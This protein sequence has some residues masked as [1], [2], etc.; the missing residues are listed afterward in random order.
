MELK[1]MLQKQKNGKFHPSWIVIVVA[2]TLLIAGIVWVPAWIVPRI[3]GKPDRVP[4]L[5]PTS[6]KVI[7]VMTTA[8]TPSILRT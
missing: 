6:P 1:R 2:L 8:S 5:S 7:M 3:D 4:Y